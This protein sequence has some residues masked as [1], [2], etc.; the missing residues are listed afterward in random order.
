MVTAIIQARTGSTR[1]PGKIMMKIN[2]EPMLYHVIKQVKVSKKISKIIIATTYLPEDDIIEDYVTK[3]GYDVFRGEPNDVLDRYYKCSKFF[4]I[5]TIVRITSDDPLIDPF[6]IDKCIDKF[7]TDKFD[8]VSNTISKKNGNWIPSLNGFPYGIA[9]E[10][11]NFS[12][13]HKA[14]KNSKNPL[15]REHLSP[16]FI[17]NPNV[18]K[19]ASISNSDDYSHIRVTVDYSED[20]EFVKSILTYFKKNEIITLEKIVSFVTKNPELLQLNKKFSFNENFKL[21]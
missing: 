11:F 3:L 19:L 15:E 21:Q 2:D 13:L 8:Y 17:K 16:Y 10:V 9:V 12:S 7:Q 5:K 20:F 14:W 18:F 1:L 4:N 6:V